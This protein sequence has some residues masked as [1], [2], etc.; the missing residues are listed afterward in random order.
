MKPTLFFALFF[1]AIQ[2]S[3]AQAPTT[4]VEAVFIKIDSAIASNNNALARELI[5]KIKPLQLTDYQKYELQLRLKR[6]SKH[7][8]ALNYEINSFRKEYPIQKSWNTVFLEYQYMLK[9]HTLL[10]RATYSNRFFDDGV[11]YELEA[12]PILSKKMYAFI[13]LAAS[14]DSFYQKFGSALSIYNNIGNGFETEIGF[15]SFDFKADSFFTFSGG[16]T[17]YIGNYYINA[18]ASI[19]PKNDSGIFQNYQLTTRYYFENATNYLFVRFGTGISPDDFNRFQQVVENP[20][21]KAYY[22][23]I[24]FSKWYNNIG[25]GATTGIL[26]EDLPNNRNG[27]QWLGSI[28][29]RYRFY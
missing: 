1:F 28:N 15:R 13:S 23:S 4:N 9:Q 14:T 11:L 27:N 2:H 24:G 29:L 19:G 20:S 16:L 6:L 21:L 26:A 18:R 12:Y 17:K 25:V 5:L 7:Q 10:A 8:V 3:T 22:A